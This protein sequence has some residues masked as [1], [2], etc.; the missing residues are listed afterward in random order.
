MGTYFPGISQRTEPHSHRRVLS[1]VRN[2]QTSRWVR[3]WRWEEEQMGG[4][5]LGLEK[6]QHEIVGGWDQGM[7]HRFSDSW[8]ST[9]P[10]LPPSFFWG[11]GI[12]LSRACVYC[13]GRWCSGGGKR[14][15]QRKIRRNQDTES[16]W[17]LGLRESH[18]CWVGCFSRVLWPLKNSQLGTVF[19]SMQHLHNALSES[20]A[21]FYNQIC[22]PRG[23]N[24]L[25]ISA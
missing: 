10:E 24:S 20:R 16:V 19:I 13:V 3:L 15:M 14:R 9:S 1:L 12:C 5:P 17:T 2:L 18:V 6:K 8:R 21:L 7:G 23:T 11:G 4:E 22:A 25:E